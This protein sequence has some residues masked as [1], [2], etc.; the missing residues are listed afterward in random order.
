[1]GQSRRAKPDSCERTRVK[2]ASANTDDD[3]DELWLLL[4][5]LYLAQ[6]S[7]A[8]RSAL[9][10]SIGDSSIQS[11]TSI[12]ASPLLPSSST[13]SRRMAHSLFFYGTLCHAAVLARVIGNPGEHLTTN[14]ALLVDHARL[15]VDRE[16]PSPSLSGTLPLE[17]C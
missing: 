1:M 9:S 11:P 8:T 14:D 15:H 10:A 16:G 17:P 2:P 13:S 12:V 3:D 7:A 5:A 4:L 6:G